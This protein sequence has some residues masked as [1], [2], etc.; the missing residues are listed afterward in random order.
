MTK[1]QHGIIACVIGAVTWGVNGVAS[2]FLLSN[3]PVE[4]SW[5]ASI[6]MA[7]AGLLLTIMIIPK[8]AI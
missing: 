1:A 3:Y 4:P 7:L 5:V 6:R 8:K 2:Q